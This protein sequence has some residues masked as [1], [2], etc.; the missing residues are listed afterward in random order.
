MINDAFGAT[1]GA[2]G[3]VQRKAFPFVFWHD[4]F[5]CRVRSSQ[6]ILV[7]FVTPRC[8]PTVGRVWHFNDHRFWA[9]KACNSGFGQFYELWVG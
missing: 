4:P 9:F 7:C 1:C 2:G 8:R 3:I 5:K 6:H